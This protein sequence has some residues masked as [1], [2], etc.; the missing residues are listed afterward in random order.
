LY[1]CQQ[2]DLLGTRQHNATTIALYLPTARPVSDPYLFPRRARVF[3]AG[4][5]APHPLFILIEGQKERKALMIMV[6]VPK[7]SD[8]HGHGHMHYRI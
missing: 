6:P 3:A 5:V 4:T 1:T 8:G 2:V 7:Y